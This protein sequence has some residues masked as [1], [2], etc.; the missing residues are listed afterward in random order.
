MGEP[1]VFR[2]ANTVQQAI[3]AE[4]ARWPN[5]ETGG[6]LLG[7]PDGCGGAL[8]NIHVGPGPNAGHF[9]AFFAPDMDYHQKEI[10][11]TYADDRHARLL[12]NWHLHPGQFDRPSGHDAESVRSI[13]REW[14]LNAPDFIACIAVRDGV[15][16]R[17]RA[18]RMTAKD[19]RFR[20]V[21]IRFVAATESA[22]APQPEWIAIP[23]AHEHLRA[24]LASANGAGF[25]AGLERHPQGM[26]MPLVNGR[27]SAELRFPRNFPFEASTLIAGARR[28]RIPPETV[29]AAALLGREL[30]KSLRRAK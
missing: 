24:L 21:P 13:L 14:N 25:R 26:R 27:A 16:V 30:R 12:G 22:T 4:F 19:L 10:D 11:R 18:W 28:Q 8:A 15:A 23:A 29:P 6:L 3:E 20:E 5:Q 9:P 17:L 1:Y 2:M 7:Y